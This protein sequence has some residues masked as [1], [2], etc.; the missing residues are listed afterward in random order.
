MINKP[1][2]LR[3]VSKLDDDPLVSL[4]ARDF[5]D[6]DPLVE[7]LPLRTPHEHWLDTYDFS[8]D[9]YS[10]FD[11]PKPETPV[12][13]E[14]FVQAFLSGLEKLFDPQNNW[15]FLKALKLSVDYCLRCQTCSEACHVYLA[16]GKQEI[17]R[18][19]FRSEVFRRIY[20]RYFT[21]AGKRLGSF[22]GADVDLNF[23]TV[24]RLLEMSYRCNICRRCVMVCPVGVDN[25]L[26][27]R[28][29]RKLFSQELGIAPAE[30]L[31]KG[32]RKHLEAGSSTGMTP[33]GFKNTI[34]FIEEIIEEKT[35][36]KIKVPVDKKGADILLI[37]NA[38][39]FLAWPENPAAFSILLN[40][41]GIDYTLSSDLVGYD[42]VNYGVWFD[43]VEFGRV[44]LR[45][46]EIAK[47]L[48]VKKIIV[49]ECGHAHKAICVTADRVFAGNSSHGEIPRESCLPLMRDIV[50][51]GEIKLDPSRNAFPVT[52]H[53]SCNIVRLMGIVRPQREIIEAVC[54]QRLREMTAH[55]VWNYCCGGGGGL[56]IMDTLNFSEWR[57]SV[58]A[59]MKVKQIINV[60]QD[61]LE[62]DIHKFV[63][64]T[65]SNCKGTI[66]D[67]ITHY[68]LKEKLGIG[69][70]GLA[71]VIVNAMVDLPQPY[72]E[73]ESD[74]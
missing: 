45:H 12:E 64:A 3:D 14:R 26:I 50:K 71:D 58:P 66:R 30:L 53:D 10:N 72:I 69:Y 67:A 15:T 52:L 32:T 48:G 16:S 24:W 42:A 37:H 23:K 41:A 40:A 18:P 34:K 4:V 1:V 61:I 22:V 31:K 38:G 43:D 17:Y 44:A 27:A 39:E 25:A 5:L 20:Q 74:L 21:L 36:K 73:W 46:I 60:F 59:R 56:A 49:G 11:L 33:A 47:N 7:Q 63:I 57:N 13:Q 68:N 9:G 62:P 70:T 2:R 29:I 51:S 55:G 28:E 8:L 19:T 65:C 35:N 54:A 6:L